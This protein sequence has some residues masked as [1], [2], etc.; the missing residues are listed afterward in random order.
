MSVQGQRYL[1]SMAWE[2]WYSQFWDKAQVVNAIRS[3][4]QRGARINLASAQGDGEW[5]LVRAA[6]FYFG[7]WRA[8]VEA[9]GFDYARVRAKPLWTRDEIVRQLRAL[10]Q[11]GEALHSRAVQLSHPGLFHAAARKRGFGAWGQAVE[12]CGVSYEQVRKY[13]KWSTPRIAAEVAQ[14]LRQGAPLNARRISGAH[15]HLYNAACHRF[16]SWGN[17]LRTLGHD[18]RQHLLRRRWTKPE[19]LEGIRRLAERGVHLSDNEA[20]RQNIALYT[21]ACRAFGGW[22]TARRKAQVAFTP[23]RP[24]RPGKDAPSPAP[25]RLSPRQDRMESAAVAGG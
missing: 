5:H 24:T 16:G 20:R 18:P 9:A 4:A 7:S 19:I 6:S 11:K 10:Q 12:A 21:A 13:E 2:H 23:R 25:P 15:A 3:R 8:A 22:R 14:L 17:A 1:W